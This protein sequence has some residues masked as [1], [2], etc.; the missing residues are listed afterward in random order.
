LSGSRRRSTILDG[1]VG[2]SS[3]VSAARKWGVRLIL[4][5]D[6]IVS[7]QVVLRPPETRPSP[8]ITAANVRAALPSAQ[9][10]DRARETFE[11]HGFQVTAVIG[12]SFSIA[13]PV[14]LF[15]DQFK[16]RLDRDPATG[17]IK[18]KRSDGSFGFELP[19]DA[20]PSDV[21]SVVATITFTPP[22][23]FGP[24]HF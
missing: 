14:R 13:G 17:A 5:E 22:P 12:N 23:D 6:E 11:E 1:H 8:G 2:R 24:S 3:R 16:T 21:T 4:D 20:L 7:A 15:Q 18:A 19:S 9:A 10:V